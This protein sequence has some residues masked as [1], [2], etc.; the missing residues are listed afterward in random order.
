MRTT[1]SLLLLSFGLVLPVQAGTPADPT[2]QSAVSTAKPWPPTADQL[3]ADPRAVWG[4]LD[5]GLRY[6]IL[7]NHEAPGRASLQMYMDVGSLMEQDNQRGVAHFLEHMAFNGTK[8][9]AA[10]E[11][12]EYFQRLG[13][14]FGGALPARPPIST[15]PCINSNCLAL[16]KSWRGTASSCFATSSTASCWTKKKSSA[17]GE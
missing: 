15:R 6:V 5:N 1:L 9:F 17:S 2:P 14:S 10:G 4:R 12:V 13:M 8:H 16:T 11:T 7:P 3:K